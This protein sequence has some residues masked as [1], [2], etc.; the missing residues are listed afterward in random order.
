MAFTVQESVIIDRPLEAVW[1]YVVE[2]DEWRHPEVKEVRKLT[3]GDPGVGTQYEDTIEMMG[4][5]MTVVNEI[6]EFNPPNRMAWE[7]VSEEGPV[8]TVEGSYELEPVDGKTRFTLTGTYEATGLTQVIS[9]I[10]RGQIDSMFE[11]FVE[12]LKEILGLREV[13]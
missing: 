7:Q 3:D 13:D 4:Q 2:H 10:I 9:P 8:R 5:E 12:Q 11:R 6:T 1:H